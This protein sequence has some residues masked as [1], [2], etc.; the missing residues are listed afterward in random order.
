MM[1]VF[2]SVGTLRRLTACVTS[3]D[4]AP[5][6][7][8][9]PIATNVR[10]VVEDERTAGVSGIDRVLLPITVWLRG[11]LIFSV[12]VIV[13]PPGSGARPGGTSGGGRA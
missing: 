2:D 9:A 8:R 11:G 12:V 5:I 4:T 3:R 1:L 13:P 7:G 10:I 6:L